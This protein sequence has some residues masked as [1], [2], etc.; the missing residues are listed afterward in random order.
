MDQPRITFYESLGKKQKDLALDFGIPES[1]MSE[2]KNA[3]KPLKVTPNQMRQ[4]IELSGAPKRNPGRFEYAELYDSL[5]VFFNKYVAVTLNRFHHDVYESLS[6]R[7]VV[8]ENLD[9]CSC[10]YEGKGQKISAINLL[11]RSTDF[12]D[13]CKDTEFNLT[14]N[15][16]L[17]EQYEQV[18]KL[19]G[20]TIRDRETFYKLRQLWSLLDIY[21]ELTFG[22]QYNSDLDFVVP[23]TPLVLT[24]NLAPS[25][26]Q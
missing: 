5:K 2:L 18:T 13:I 10:Q 1:R 9:K 6:N 12:A 26:A 11:I 15:G 8:D 14:V 19:Y 23:L 21:P 4:I 22:T 17:I 24:G 20:L 16:A 3:Q 7:F 25:K